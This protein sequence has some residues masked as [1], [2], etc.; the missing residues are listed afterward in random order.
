VL[1]RAAF[2]A[3]S[4]AG[5]GL[6]F[7]LHAQEGVGDVVYVPTPQVVVDTMLRMGKVGPQDF[8]IDLGSGDGRVV[9]S[10][11]RRGA[12]ALGVD[13]DRHLLGVANEAARREGV[14]ERAIFVEQNLFE[15]DLRAATVITS[16]LLPEMNL[17]LRPRILDL[18]P[19]TRV[20]AH[21]YHMGQWLPDE[22]ETLSVPEKKVGTPGISY[23]YFWLVPARVAGTW[24]ADIPF[25]AARAPLEFELE[26]RFQVLKAKP[27][28][29]EGRPTRLR[30]PTL[31]GDEITFLLE[32]G[33]TQLPLR[34][35]FRGRAVGDEIR[36][37]V[38]VSDPARGQREQAW[39]ARRIAVTPAAME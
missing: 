35:Q 33:A 29:V 25:G 11:A 36:G 2:F 39:S 1:R 34:Y 4:I 24:R 8:L 23:V 9:I 27:T 22:R 3:G 37:T 5:F 17:K 12:R 18:K 16:Y 10:A 13:L 32:V 15:T 6:A 30:A 20:V 38:V 28:A 14:A 26:Q 31:R 7:A 21:D 19:G